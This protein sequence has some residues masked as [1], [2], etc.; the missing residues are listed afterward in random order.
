MQH[1]SVAPARIPASS[2][3]S[4]HR[5]VTMMSCPNASAFVPM[6][7]RGERDV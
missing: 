3:V 2:S 4:G 5:N 6:R 1:T 7:I